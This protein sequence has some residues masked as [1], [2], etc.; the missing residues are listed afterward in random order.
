[1]LGIDLGSGQPAISEEQAG[2]L[3]RELT[4]LAGGEVSRPA[5]AAA[6]MID[7]AMSAGVGIPTVEA[8]R[9]ERE[10]VF[11]ALTLGRLARAP[12]PE[13]ALRDL[14]LALRDELAP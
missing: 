13:Q 14:R 3:V 9:A 2:W 4:R 5:Y 8:T 10:A 12:E 6:V 1:M 11:D 7:H